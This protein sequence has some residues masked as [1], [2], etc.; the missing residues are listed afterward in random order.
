M[1]N[2]ETL[3][4]T[5]NANAE[6]AAQGIDRLITSL[7]SL[8]EALIKPFSD[9]RDFN[10]ELRTLKQLSANI[11]FTTGAVAAISRAKRIKSDYDP[12]TGGNRNVDVSKMTY[13]NAKPENVW[14]KEFEANL[15]AYA[16]KKQQMQEAV[17]R[18]NARR[19]AT[20][21]AAEEAGK[22]S[23]QAAKEEMNIRGG[24]AKT[25]I[26]NASTY[27][28]LKLKYDSLK[29]ATIDDA[30]AG[31]LTNE[32]LVQRTFQLRKLEE[33]LQ[34]TKTTTE[35]NV[36]TL[37]R[38]K[39]GFSK[40]AS[41]LSGIYKRIKRIAVT[42]LIR[43]AIRALIKD[44]K[45]G[46]TNVTEWSRTVNGSLGKAMD[47][48]KAKTL[49]LK[50]SLGAALAP[51]LE[52][53][54]PVLNS[55]SSAI[56]KV[57]NWLGQLIALLSGKTSY[58]SAV[59]QA[60]SSTDALADS[61]SGAGSAA[62]EALAAF[63]ELNVLQND[64]SGGGGGGGTTPVDYSSMFQE[65]TKFDEKIREIADFLK[66]NFES[67]RDMAIATG[68][69]ILSWKLG[70]AFANTL[71]L[72]SQIFGYVA[73]GAVIAI[74]LQ[75]NWLLMNQYLNTGEDGWFWASVLTTA[76]GSTAAWAIA[77]K[78]IGGQAGSYAAGITLLLTAATDIKA[79]IEHTNVS[80][81]SAE[82]IKTNIKAALESAAGIA[83]ITNAAG[84][85]LAGTIA[86]ASGAALITFGVATGLKTITDKKNVE[87][88]SRETIFG[89]LAAAIPIGLGLFVLGSGAVAAGIAT[90]FTFGAVIALKAMMPKD[91][92]TWGDIELTDEQVQAFV[93]QKM[94]NVN[95]KATMNVIHDKVQ[96]TIAERAELGV[97]I[98]QAVG[99]FKVIKLG[100]AETQDYTQMQTDVNTLIAQVNTFISAAKAEG[101]L[102]LQYTPT[103]AGDDDVETGAWFTNYN[104]GWDSIQKFVESKGKV[105]GDWLTEQESKSI[106]DA[107][108]DVVAAAM[109]QLTAVTTAIQQAT[110]GGEAFADLKITLG[111]LDEQSFEKVISEFKK[112]KAEL[113]KEYEDLVKDQYANQAALVEAMKITLGEGY[114]D[115]PE[116]Q[117][118]LAELERMGANM[119][120]AVIDGVNSASQP[121]TT[122][123][124]EWLDKQLAG[125]VDV[126]DWADAFERSGIFSAED[127]QGAL[128]QVMESA[129]SDEQ[130][131][132]ADM[133][134]FTGWD[135][136]SEELKQG[137]ISALGVLNSENLGWLK[138]AGIPIDE[139]IKFS[140]WDKLTSQQKLK[141]VN[142]LKDAF[143]ASEAIKAAK[144]AGINIAE[145]VSQGMGSQDPEIRKIA[146]EWS[147][148]LEDNVDDP[149]VKPEYQK[150]EVQKIAQ[151]MYNFF[152]E[153]FP[154]KFGV[155]PESNKS[156]TETEAGKMNNWFSN[157]L[158][159][160][161]TISPIT[162]ETDA[163]T[164]AGK[165]NTWFSN[166]LTKAYT[167]TP[168][169]YEP[170]AK[171]AATSA[172]NWFK[173]AFNDKYTVT[174]QKS[175]T[176]LEGI[177]NDIKEKVKDVPVKFTAS[178]IA[179]EVTELG[180][181]VGKAIIKKLKA[182]KINVTV[183]KDAGGEGGGGGNNNQT[184][185]LLLANE[186]MSDIVDASYSWNSSL[187][188]EEIVKAINDANTNQNELLRQQ[189]EL[190]RSILSKTG[191]VTIN[192]SS[193]LGR[194]VDQSLQMYGAITG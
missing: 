179:S 58:T 160:T 106:K 9:L 108:P 190:L 164:A 167:I 183:K 54:I 53:L 5:I 134:G 127:L 8:S 77:K 85:T 33:E 13:P 60:T 20:K 142:S 90:A 19:T 72:L 51:V 68:V 158:T 182:M 119:S 148:I 2:L 103:L 96:M 146:K 178:K 192:A 176:N 18:G 3:E 32:Q 186:D 107:V 23:L 6:G 40:F 180:E 172:N 125:T 139:I 147:K 93:D 35:E 52:A 37:A 109:E 12:S 140:G 71:P 17:E 14:K 78:L 83:F 75:A 165:T 39:E 91:K 46:I 41:G 80:A 149:H 129:L 133:I 95:V 7:S 189:N 171:S 193:A 45:E 152:R 76:V 101:K 21:L 194:V 105:I 74:T 57:C 15:A 118:A 114:E 116:Y 177:L 30:R 56:I 89:A 24:L 65:L 157:A 143:G 29:Q 151:G 55:L 4:L 110:A 130:I 144:D 163:T 84:A 153:K 70:N 67:L 126:W 141:F 92:I 132:L 124:K 185:G 168:K 50:N 156:A 145:L 117:A 63:D 31:K 120:Q 73:T 174:F 34:N 155:K 69:A 62:K 154:E 184:K 150:S 86:A 131:E 11:R 94:F 1:A 28:L 138:Q 25:I 66:N 135:L 123:I 191:N 81:L 99:T 187:D 170:D 100:L 175:D 59:E 166:A 136:L 137:F 161:Y 169:T 121:G 159:K 26:E 44:V 87:W 79:N 173:N 122:M 16:A 47:S 48:F 61:A 128:R 115:D 102:T 27:D 49:T 88:S 10:T 64:T 42:M 111:D 98:A 22:Q 188:P 36:S 113:T 82:S 97:A 104:Q 162:N 43:S 181:A 112:Y 38:L